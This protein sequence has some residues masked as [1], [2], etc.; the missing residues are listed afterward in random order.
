MLSSIG[1]SIS[2]EA[3]ECN[4]CLFMSGVIRIICDTHILLAK[5]FLTENSDTEES[6]EPIKN[7]KNSLHLSA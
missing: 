2:F 7:F 3:K 4:F 1:L 5:E 6:D